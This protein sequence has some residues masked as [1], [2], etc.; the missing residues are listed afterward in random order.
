MKKII[1]LLSLTLLA[2]CSATATQNSIKQSKAL[3]GKTFTLEASKEGRFFSPTEKIKY[4]EVDSYL[5]HVFTDLRFMLDD[6]YPE[7]PLV[8][9]PT[10]L[11]TQTSRAIYASWVPTGVGYTVLPTAHY[12]LITDVSQEEPV[13]KRYIML[14]ALEKISERYTVEEVSTP[15][16]HYLIRVD[17][18]DQTDFEPTV[19]AMLNEITDV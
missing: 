19:I 11:E 7:P 10:I 2:G 17:E 5:N 9:R 8:V 3:Y 18:S 14:K 1:A 4:F 15:F 6:K 13:T 12:M 16:F